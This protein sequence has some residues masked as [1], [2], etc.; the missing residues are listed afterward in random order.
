MSQSFL[1][2]SISVF[3]FA[4]ALTDLCCFLQQFGASPARQAANFEA[5]DTITLENSILV[6][7]EA[8]KQDNPSNSSFNDNDCFCC[9]HVLPSVPIELSNLIIKPAESEPEQA[10]L[11]KPPSRNLFHP[12]RAA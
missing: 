6:S 12:P 1:Y 11:P 3:F 4:L 8:S 2:R 7:P 9:A 5:F 10:F